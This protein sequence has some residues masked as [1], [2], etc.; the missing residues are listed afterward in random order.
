MSQNWTTVNWLLDPWRRT[1][2]V[3]H[4]IGNNSTDQHRIVW[5][6]REGNSCGCRLTHSQLP[7]WEVGARGGVV[8]KALCYKPA[9]RGFHSRW[10]HFSVTSFRLHYGPGVSTSNK[11]EYQV[12]FL[13]VKAAGAYD[14][15]LY[16][17]PVPLSWNLGTLTSWN[18][19]GHSRPVTGLLY[20]LSFFGSI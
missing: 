2:A 18:P 5:R 8:V 12:Y 14:W 3:S 1:D 17:H 9:G 7:F 4:I 6:K 19:L 16:H 20:L 10:C 13:G 11:N 15:Q